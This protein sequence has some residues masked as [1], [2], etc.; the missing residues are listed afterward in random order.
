VEL[1][2]KYGYQLGTREQNATVGIELP[3]SAD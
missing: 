2:G 3:P 1:A